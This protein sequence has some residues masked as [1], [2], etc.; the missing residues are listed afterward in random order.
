MAVLKIRTQADE[1]NVLRTSCDP[2][3]KFDRSLRDLVD[4]MWD[5]MY[6]AVGVGLAATQIGSTLR[7]AVIDTIQ[8]SRSHRRLV[9]V[10]P[11]IAAMEGEQIESEGC[12]SMPGLT[13][14][15]P[16]AAVVLVTFQDLDG[17]RQSLRAKD[18]LARAIQHEC[19]HLDGVLCNSKAP[20]MK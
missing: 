6:A 20:R 10:N 15:I 7:V 11:T 1:F 3:T 14:P 12:L 2:V 8:R 5:S 9:L 16:R 13:W 19:D 17:T 18:L 4:D